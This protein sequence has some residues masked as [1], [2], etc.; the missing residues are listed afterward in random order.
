MKA[1]DNR[2]FDHATKK[3]NEANLELHRPEEDVVSF[4]VCK[5][6]QYAIENY[7]KGFPAATR[8]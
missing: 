3:L 7:L 2:F 8:S 6:S 5:N 4:L 1:K